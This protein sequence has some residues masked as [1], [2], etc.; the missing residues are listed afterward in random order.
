[1]GRVDRKGSDVVSQPAVL[2]L[3]STDNSPGEDALSWLTHSVRAVL[4]GVD[5]VSISVLNGRRLLSVGATDP[6]VEAAD[7]LQYK[8][9]EGPTIDASR[10]AWMS[11]TDD[12]A[13]T[14]REQTCGSDTAVPG[15]RSLTAISLSAQ[16]YHVGALNLYATGPSPLA[17]HVLDA[18]LDLARVIGD[19][20]ALSAAV[21]A[22]AQVMTAGVDRGVG[23]SGAAAILVPS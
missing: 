23:R 19:L 9:G 14:L 15:F 18:A 22:V 4:S 11:S 2:G 3:L 16:G 7:T 6:L 20:V 13:A 10:G 21:D 17:Q 5:A 12:L 1:M 8:R